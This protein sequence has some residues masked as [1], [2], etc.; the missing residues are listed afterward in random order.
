VEGEAN[1]AL[2]RLLGKVLDVP[3]SAVRIVGGATS[4]KK[5]IHVAGIGAPEARKR[6]EP[7][8]RPA[9]K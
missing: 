3:P 2:S 6:L 9:G 7:H 1:A 4:R 5:R 8:L